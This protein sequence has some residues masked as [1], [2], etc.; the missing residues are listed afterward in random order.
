MLTLLRSGDILSSL[1]AELCEKNRCLNMAA[2]DIFFEL[3]L[4]LVADVTF[5]V[6]VSTSVF[7]GLGS[8][9]VSI[10]GTRSNVIF[11]KC[12]SFVIFGEIVPALFSVT[13]IVLVVDGAL[14]RS[15]SFL[16]HG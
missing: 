11:V 4:L 2:L 5:S 15:N 1:F 9:S 14:S 8:D 6:A 7:D 3:K 10:G 12:N 16:S 13:P